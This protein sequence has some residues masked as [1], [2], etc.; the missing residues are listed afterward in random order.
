MSALYSAK[1]GVYGFVPGRSIA[2]NARAHVASSAVLNIDLEDFFPSIHY[3]RVRG[4]FS[5]FPFR[6]GTEAAST[7]AQLCC[8]EGR[9]PVGAP[10]SPILTNFICRRLDSELYGLARKHGCS[11]SRYADDIT[12]SKRTGELPVQIVAQISDG[13][14]YV[15]LGKS[16]VDVIQRHDFRINASKS[17]VRF[18]A[19]RQD[20]TGLTVNTRINVP[21]W[22]VRNLRAALHAW[23]KNGKRPTQERLD[24]IDTATK[25]R[26]RPSPSLETHVA[27]K[28]AFLR[29]IRGD[30]DAVCT[31]YE[32]Q[33]V[34][35]NR[36]APRAVICGA[37]ANYSSF[38]L[39]TLWIVHGDNGDQGTAFDLNGVGLL[40]AAHVLDR[41]GDSGVR[42]HVSRAVPPYDEFP[43]TAV[44]RCK[45]VDIAIL[46]TAANRNAVLARVTQGHGFPRQVVVCG[47]PSWRH[48]GDSG[49]YASAD[50]VQVKTLHGMSVASVSHPLLSGASGGPILSGDNR[51][52]GIITRNKD[53]DV[54]PN[55]CV[56]IDHVAE[57]AKAKRELL[58]T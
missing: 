43:V 16:L 25:T 4:V 12:I 39:E 19:R 10:T 22:Y 48:H 6:L 42:F 33:H 18:A 20:V 2:D 14:R 36:G 40:T 5:R 29:M 26:S 30:G 15:E 8:Y 34:R 32:L 51:V 44:R 24:L 58:A 27:G 21:R 54:L 49:V 55:G 13:G 50:V 57:A 38:R 52:V 23:A 56:H 37:S 46:E 11:Y 53:D 9:L 28:L 3:G 35:V 17:R 31:R 1:R 7:L 45:H 47:F 41:L